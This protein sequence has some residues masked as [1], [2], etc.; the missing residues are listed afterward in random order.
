M[1]DSNFRLNDFDVVLRDDDHPVSDHDTVRRPVLS[2]AEAA[3]GMP[4][5]PESVETLRQ[6]L[7]EHEQQLRTLQRELRLRDERILQL[8]RLNT[9]DRDEA[10]G[11]Q[12]EEIIA[13]GLVLESVKDPRIV[14]RISRITTTIG[15]THDSNIVLKTNSVSRCHARIVVAADSTYLI[16]QNS[17]NGCTVNGERISRQIINDGDIVAFGDAP[18]RFVTGAPLPEGEDRW[19]EETQVL[20]DESVVFTRAATQKDNPTR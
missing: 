17:R 7:Q 18:F 15:R 2:S 20:L 1:K 4:H 10:N 13:M 3:A 9:E 12:N 8:E 5:E 6:R 11:I 16:D 19:M 14:H